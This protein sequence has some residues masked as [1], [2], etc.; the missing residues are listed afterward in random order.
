MFKPPI[1]SILLRASGPLFTLLI[2]LPLIA[3]AGLG[4]HALADLSSLLAQLETTLPR[5]LLTSAALCVATLAVALLLGVPVAWFSTQYRLPLQRLSI[6]LAVLPLALPAY[7]VAYGYTD[8]LDYSGW[9]AIHIR[10]GMA[11]LGL[12]P[13]SPAQW[14]PIHSVG[15]AALV[16]GVSLSPYI[17]L[18]ARAAF[19]ESPPSLQDAARSMGLGS[20]GMF[21]RLALPMA[22]PALAA[23]SAL[24]VMETLADYGTVAFFSVQTFSTG[25]Y[26]TWFSYGDRSGAALLGLLMLLLALGLVYLERRARGR[27]EFFAT[28]LRMRSLREVG[29]KR[30]LVLCL[31]CLLPGL[32]GFVLPV[33]F[34]LAAAASAETEL[35]LPQLGGQALTS[36]HYALMAAVVLVPVALVLS[37]RQRLLGSGLPQRLA[38]SGYA[39]PG[40]VV[41]VG[42]LSISGWVTEMLSWVGI[43]FA[44]TTTV[45]LILGGYLTRFFTVAQVSME[46]GLGRI[47][48][49]L[50]WSARSLG[51]SAW[52]VLARLHLPL[53]SRS[54]WVAALIVFVDVVKELPVTLVLRPFNV[55]TLAVAAHGLASDERLA[56]AAWPALTIALVGLVPVLLLGPQKRQ[57]NPA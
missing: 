23:G 54:I 25:L 9:L 48:P 38:G 31:V 42:L 39:V 6:W 55:E 47:T 20:Q 21:W 43:G 4:L 1:S 22:R 19:E 3:V 52:Q 51:L 7:V 46:A 16:L 34:L 12:T 56:E 15:G 53:L 37:Y 50:D 35:V 30:R 57:R 8:A 24:V 49:S 40:L 32:L 13:P 18:L 26:K 27:A 2:G 14:P 44:L 5:Y 28:P 10:E 29:P 11:A 17:T 33:A 36:V 45:L 41:A